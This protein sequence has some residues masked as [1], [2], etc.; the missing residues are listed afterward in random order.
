M[1]YEFEMWQVSAIYPG[2]IR[3][4]SIIRLLKVLIVLL[5]TFKLSSI[6]DNSPLQQ[7][8]H[9]E[10]VMSDRESITINC[11]FTF[12]YIK[13][14][15]IAWEEEIVSLNDDQNFWFSVSV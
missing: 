8:S 14:G 6:Y 4:S 7:R 9:S 15:M 2:V 13:W 12:I 10:A 3:L 11:H 5:F 1:H